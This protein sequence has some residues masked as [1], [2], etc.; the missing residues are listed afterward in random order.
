MCFDVMCSTP[1]PQP[2]LDSERPRSAAAFPDA[3]PVSAPPSGQHSPVLGAGSVPRSSTTSP[4][5]TESSH[6]ADA[7]NDLT[8]ELSPAAGERPRSAAF[9]VNRTTRARPR[10]ATP[11]RGRSMS[12][13]QRIAKPS[14]ILLSPLSPER[15]TPAKRQRLSQVRGKKMSASPIPVTRS[16]RLQTRKADAGAEEV[17]RPN[18]RARASN[19][20]GHPDTAGAPAVKRQLRGRKGTAPMRNAARIESDDDLDV[21][22]WGPL[23]LLTLAETASRQAQEMQEADE[24]AAAAQQEQSSGATAAV[25]HEAMDPLDEFVAERRQV[26]AAEPAT[27]PLPSIPAAK[28]ANRPEPKVTRDNVYA[29][30]RQ[31]QLQA[32]AAEERIAMELHR[33]GKRPFA[34]ATATAAAAKGRPAPGPPARLGSPSRVGT[35]EQVPGT[36]YTLQHRN[37]STAQQ[38]APTSGRPAQQDSIIAAGGGQVCHLSSS[39]LPT[40]SGA[41]G[42]TDF[43][44][45]F[46]AQRAATAAAGSMRQSQR[47]AAPTATSAGIVSAPTHTKAQDLLRSQQASPGRPTAAADIAAA[48]GAPPSES[49]P[50]DTAGLADQHEAADIDGSAGV[51]GNASS[52]TTAA[53]QVEA[54]ADGGSSRDAWAKKSDADMEIDGL[55]THWTPVRT[56]FRHAPLVRAC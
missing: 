38:Y 14:E 21:D 7:V 19:D 10:K 12:P 27:E 43:A 41:H 1:L 24:A 45:A 32:A 9:P 36:S 16:V 50:D 15:G 56:S 31:L 2:D 51:D 49:A 5:Q 26:L 35:S 25:E 55:L 53:E 40:S 23:S 33:R 47:A 22:S 8:P 34:A 17:M 46:A 4:Q 6:A 20:A 44:S 30:H 48:G 54:G 28:S 52:Q 37:S 29:V 39:G 11:K 42:P 13:V 3:A 18:T